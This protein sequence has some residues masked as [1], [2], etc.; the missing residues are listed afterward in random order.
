MSA[1]METCDLLLHDPLPVCGSRPLE[2]R[3][4]ERG[5]FLETTSNEYARWPIAL[6]PYDNGR[7]DLPDRGS[8][9]TSALGGLAAKKGGSRWLSS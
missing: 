9:V 5:S 4:V 6:Y 2:A 1:V 7:A 3:I 8:H